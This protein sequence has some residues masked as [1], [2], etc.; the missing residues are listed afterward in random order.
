MN[1]EF[2]FIA[3][4]KKGHHVPMHD[5]PALEIVYYLSGHGR[6]TVQ[7]TLYEFHRNDF[8]LIPAGTLHNQINQTGVTSFCLGLSGS[9]LEGFQGNWRDADGMIHAAIQR[10]QEEMSG[11]KPFYQETAHGILLEIIG[12]VKRAAGSRHLQPSKSNVVTQALTLIQQRKGIVS[13]AD[14]AD[15]L[16]VSKDYLRHL[17]QEQTSQSPIRHIINTRIEKARAL[18]ADPE[19]PV[20]EVA[21][22]CGFE[23]FYYFSRLFKK[24]TRLSPSAYR[25]SI[26]EKGK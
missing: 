7:K 25:K 8:T 5:H 12:L 23:N 18:L 6:T 17:F 13:V 15:Q 24:E 21:R 19:L 2:N 20:T 16:Y 9:G 4:L 22:Q 11:K 10:F 14:L 26:T 3:D 1:L